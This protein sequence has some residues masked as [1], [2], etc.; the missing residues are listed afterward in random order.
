[1]GALEIQDRLNPVARIKIF[2][3]TK[4]VWSW[5]AAWTTAG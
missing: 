1:M 3:A 5:A 4:V 2:W